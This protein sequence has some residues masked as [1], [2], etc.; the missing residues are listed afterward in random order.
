MVTALASLLTDRPVRGLLGKCREV[1]RVS[2]S[3]R[4]IVI[5]DQ[6]LKRVFV[7]GLEHLEPHASVDLGHL[8]QALVDQAT[9]QIARA[10]QVPIKGDRRRGSRI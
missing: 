10:G 2:P 9:D 1:V 6:A 8:Q 7:N 3:E 4:A 5:V